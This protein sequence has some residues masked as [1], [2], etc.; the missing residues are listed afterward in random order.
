MPLVGFVSPGDPMWQSTL[1]AMD[2]D[3]VSASLV[4]LDT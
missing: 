4:S 3:L 1:Q 2:D